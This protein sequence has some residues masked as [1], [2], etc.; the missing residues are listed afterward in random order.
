MDAPSNAA[1]AGYSQWLFPLTALGS[2]PSTATAGMTVE[3]ELYERARGVE[4]LFRLGV[5]LVLFVVC[6]LQS[7]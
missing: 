1:V 5:S 3:K 6:S 7:P 2:T 4:F